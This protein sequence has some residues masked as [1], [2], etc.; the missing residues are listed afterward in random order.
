MLGVWLVVWRKWRSALKK[1]GSHNYL[2]V[3]ASMVAFSRSV[4]AGQTPWD[5]PAKVPVLERGSVRER[6]FG[7]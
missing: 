3:K 7:G 4:H 1:M 2:S 6:D 5:S